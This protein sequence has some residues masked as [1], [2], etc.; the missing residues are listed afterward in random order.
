MVI[1]GD[2]TIQKQ[3]MFLKITNVV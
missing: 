3:E 1:Y 2:R